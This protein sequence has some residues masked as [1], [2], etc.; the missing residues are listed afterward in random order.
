MLSPKQLESART[1][2]E[3]LN[4]RGPWQIMLEDSSG[5]LMRLSVVPDT[6]TAV[7][8]AVNVAE[9]QPIGRW[10]TIAQPDSPWPVLSFRGQVPA[11]MA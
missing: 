5:R 4:Y 11:H 9:T 6:E 7:L 2:E 10:V 1:L 8:V 3:R